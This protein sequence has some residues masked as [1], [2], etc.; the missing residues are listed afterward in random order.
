VR[1]DPGS[2]PLVFPR[3]KADDP[4]SFDYLEIIADEMIESKVGK[5]DRKMFKQN[6]LEEV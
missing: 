6:T 1:Y 3:E 4:F 5:I 2:C